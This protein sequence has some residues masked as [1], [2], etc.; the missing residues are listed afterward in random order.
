[1]KVDFAATAQEFL[2]YVGYLFVSNEARY[3]LIHGLAKR[4][5]DNPHYY[6][7]DDPWFCTVSDD[8]AILAA[9]MR[10]PPYRVILAHFCGNP[11]DIA[12]VLVE[13]IV[14]L[15]RVIPGTTGDLKL[16]DEFARQWCSQLGVHIEDVMVER[17]YKMERLNEIMLAPG[18]MR[19]ASVE[20]KELLAKW[21]H[22]FYQDVY[23]ASSRNVPEN[24][25][26]PAIESKSVYLW[27]D[28]APVSMAIKTRPTENGIS[29]GGVY[30]P[31]QFRQR[32]YATSCVAIL[33]K[34][35]LHSGYK[36]CSLYT[37]LAN[38]ISNSIYQNIGFK[39]V[40]DSAEYSFSFP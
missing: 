37:N 12:G 5:V 38:P 34:E 8:G 40:C 23:A 17:I 19:L 11:V 28:G 7:K 16:A 21:H 27:E 14:K 9:A 20:E 13:S 32:G 26:T 25:I 29:I 10:T 30:T 24:D 33:C 36:F 31:P 18:S 35:L 39:E 3:S 15:S 6:G 2:S 1:M 4:L 22:L